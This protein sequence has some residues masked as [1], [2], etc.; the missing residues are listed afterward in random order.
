MTYKRKEILED[1]MESI[2]LGLQV[3]E[4]M[5]Q[6]RQT[7]KQLKDLRNEYAIA[8]HEYAELTGRAYVGERWGK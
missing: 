6:D 8:Q 3:F 7:L 2:I 4:R 5:P 1:R